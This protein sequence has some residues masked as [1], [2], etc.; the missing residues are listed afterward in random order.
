MLL[1]IAKQPMSSTNTIKKCR[2][3]HISAVD[4]TETECNVLWSAGNVEAKE[5]K[6]MTIADKLQVRNKIQYETLQM[7]RRVDCNGGQILKL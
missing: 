2:I 1:S 3:L 4:W 5:G 7:L 6:R